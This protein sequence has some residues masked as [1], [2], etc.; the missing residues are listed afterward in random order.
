MP[1][2]R[3]PPCN[4]AS[5]TAGLLRLA[6][7]RSLCDHETEAKAEHANDE[8]D[9]APT[10]KKAIKTAAKAREADTGQ[11][12]G[13]RAQQDHR[14]DE[15]PPESKLFHPIPRICTWRPVVRQGP[16]GAA[17]GLTVHATTHS[18]QCRNQ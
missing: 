10:V 14:G 16:T 9:T 11:R 18:L 13:R 3:G 1:A 7:T 15:P 17:P 4:A 12:R 8:A 5:S 6:D 2:D